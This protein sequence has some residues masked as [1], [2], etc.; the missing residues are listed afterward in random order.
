MTCKE[1]QNWERIG[2]D[3]I[4][5]HSERACERVLGLDRHSDFSFCGKN[6]LEYKSQIAVRGTLSEYLG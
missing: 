2:R 4:T 6:V 3:L 5:R 1:D